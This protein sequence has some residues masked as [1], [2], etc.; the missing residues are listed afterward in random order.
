MTGALVLNLVN[1]STYGTDVAGV[2]T[3]G[4]VEVDFGWPEYVVIVPTGLTQ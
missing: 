3:K 1:G 2:L 4:T